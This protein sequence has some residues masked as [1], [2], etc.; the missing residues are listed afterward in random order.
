MMTITQEPES[1]DEDIGEDQYT[2]LTG[3]IGPECF[4]GAET[5]KILV[6]ELY[7]ADGQ[8]DEMSPHFII[9]TGATDTVASP[10]KWSIIAEAIRREDP[11]SVVKICKDRGRATRFRVASGAIVGAY[12]RVIISGKQGSIEGYSIENPAAIALLGCS[13]LRERSAALDYSSNQ[14]SW[15]DTAGGER[16]T[17]LQTAS[18]GH[19]LVNPAELFKC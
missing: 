4:G 12:A 8:K 18:N 16:L 6:L 1:N 14:L 19:L 2:V 5:G 17:A 10:E 15:V 13:W 11:T 7:S 3:E 9:D